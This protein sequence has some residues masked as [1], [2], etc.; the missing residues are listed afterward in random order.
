MH[1]FNLRYHIRFHY[2]YKTLLIS[3]VTSQC[4]R[5]NIVISLAVTNFKDSSY[6]NMFIFYPIEHSDY[7]S[8]E[9]TIHQFSIILLNIWI[10]LHLISM[11]VKCTYRFWQ[12]PSVGRALL[13]FVLKLTFCQILFR[14]CYFQLF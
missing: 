5:R 13:A 7:I 8:G 6:D 2:Q 14:C 1:L 9:M 4:E 12:S 11:Y 10:K 3:V